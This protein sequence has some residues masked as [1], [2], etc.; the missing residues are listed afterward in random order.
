VPCP[1]AHPPSSRGVLTGGN[2][3]PHPAVSFLTDLN[4]RRP[5]SPQPAAVCALTPQPTAAA[6]GQA[7][8]PPR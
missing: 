7:P 8:G 1:L 2:A 5:R 3:D 6:S 4:A